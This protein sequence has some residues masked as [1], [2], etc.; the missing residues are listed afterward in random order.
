M[1]DFD[2]LLTSHKAMSFSTGILEIRKRGRQENV[3]QAIGYFIACKEEVV[4]VFVP[5]KNMVFLI[6]SQQTIPVSFCNLQNVQN[7]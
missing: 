5:A 2:N 6:A 3:F 1:H 4:K 7:T